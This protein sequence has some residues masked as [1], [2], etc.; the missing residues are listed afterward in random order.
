MN[1]AFILQH[2]VL[3][4]AEGQTILGPGAALLVSLAVILI[5]CLPR[6]YV[7]APFLVTALFIPLGQEVVAG[8]LHFP[9]FRI[10]ILFGIVRVL[11]SG[12]STGKEAEKFHLNSIDR[13]LI[14]WVFSSVITFTLLWGSTDALVNRMG[15][16]FNAF[17]TY[18]FLR[19][20]YRSEEDVVRTIKVLAMICAV[21]AIFMVQEHFTGRNY[22]S[23][24]GGV[25]TF[26]PIRDGNLRA[27]GPFGHPILAGT[28]GATLL[29]LFWGL[30]CRDRKSRGVASLGI[31]SSFVVT[32]ASM[33]ST[34]LGALFAACVGIGFWPL[35]KR[36][37]SIRWGIVFGLVALQMVM[38]APV[39]ALIER[40]NLI[41]GNS[42]W[43][44]FELVDLF[45]RRFTDWFL[46]G[47]KNY[48]SWGIDTWDQSNEYVLEGE[49][50]G[51]IT[52]VLFLTLLVRCF[53]A[54]GNA[55]KA[56][57]SRPNEEKFVWAF[58]AALF[59][60]VVAFF[61]VTYFDQTVVAWYALLAM[62]S[63][64][65]LSGFAYQHSEASAN[66][67]GATPLRG[68]NTVRPAAAKN[69]VA[70]RRP[71]FAWNQ[72]PK[73]EPDPA[74]KAGETMQPTSTRR[75][76]RGLPVWRP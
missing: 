26:T 1:I 38:K 7:I 30:W 41:S 64:L 44:R 23:I 55:R 50:G 74:K 32:I 66:V 19:F 35:R 53:R 22:F 63:T 40:I 49:R 45:I 58:G 43:H 61:G 76:G 5:L 14:F 33:S 13:I 37:R 59:A 17:G 47:A 69:A 9:M 34:P 46:L 12:R 71:G 57:E 72:A 54:I 6:K 4:G 24:F 42:S 73:Q 60:N 15:F 51:L 3:G 10:L 8:G 75:T 65:A 56:V 31:A 18:F 48:A 11:F 2:Q 16:L 52:F 39:W 29:P 25:P 21:L 20:L 67:L 62:I 68:W 70:T 27:Q 36:M 28:L